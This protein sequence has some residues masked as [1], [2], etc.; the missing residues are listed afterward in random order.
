MLW[1]FKT[2]VFPVAVFFMV[3]GSSAL[4]ALHMVVLNHFAKADLHWLDVLFWVTSGKSLLAFIHI[5]TFRTPKHHIL[6]TIQS[7][8]GKV[9]L[10]DLL[11]QFFSIAAT[12]FLILAMAAAPNTTFVLLVNGVQPLFLTVLG[13]CL[14]YFNPEFFYKRAFDRYLSIR[15]GFLV[16]I[17]SGLYMLIT[18]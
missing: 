16:L 14:G 11:N 15:L 1:D 5:C 12:A 3:M 8:K 6:S 9:I 10:W 7:S 13:L 17:F 4:I 2:R 18:Q